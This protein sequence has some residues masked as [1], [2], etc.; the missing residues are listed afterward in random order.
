MVRLTV[1]GNVANIKDVIASGSMTTCSYS[2]FSTANDFSQHDSFVQVIRNEVTIFSLPKSVLFIFAQ[3]IRGVEFR[4]VGEILAAQT[5]DRNY[6]TI[7]NQEVGLVKAL[8]NLYLWLEFAIIAANFDPINN[9]ANVFV[10][11]TKPL[12]IEDYLFDEFVLDYTGKAGTQKDIYLL[13]Q[14]FLTSEENKLIV[15]LMNLNLISR[16]TLVVNHL[17]K[18][19]YFVS[20]LKPGRNPDYYKSNIDPTGNLTIA[21]WNKILYARDKR[22]KKF[23][24]GR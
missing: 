19:N 7:S 5:G 24:E 17:Q 1:S 21:L 9:P 13:P 8:F 10:P 12:V 3:N 16:V 22:I 15:Q 4:Q 14:N 2:L 23:V 20:L 18:E 6:T 11:N